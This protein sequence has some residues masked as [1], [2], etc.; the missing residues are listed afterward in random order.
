MSGWRASTIDIDFRP[1]PDSDEL[2]RA[3]SELKRTLNVNLET[4][5]PLEFLPAPPD[6]RERSPFI[7]QAGAIEVRHMDF[8]VQALAKLERGTGQDLADVD[9]M[10][11]RGLLTRSELAD[12]FETIRPSLYRFLAVDEERLARNVAAWT[13]KRPSS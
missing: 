4:A 6:W 11:E 9:A 10:L 1:E 8:R 12:A 5:S 3:V 7:K 2:M 13:T